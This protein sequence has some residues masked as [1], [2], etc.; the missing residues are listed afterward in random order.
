MEVEQRIQ[1]DPA[2]LWTLITDIDLP[3]RYSEELQAVE[4]LDGST[5]V[6]V[7]HRFRG[8]NEHPDLGHWETEC[9]ITEVEPERRW[10]Y[11]VRATGDGM[12]GTM[13]TWG[14]ELD[15]GRDAVRVRQWARMGPDRSGLSFAIESMPDKEGRIIARRL[16]EWR[17]N[18]EANLEGLRALAEDPTS[19]A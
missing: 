13:A 9:V 18:M 19:P 15:P 1:A 14:F 4:W 12:E 2:D 8:R 10:V 3:A 11:E 6:A 17:R 16:A 5:G 7:G